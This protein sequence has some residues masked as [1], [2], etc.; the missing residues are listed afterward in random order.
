MDLDQKGGREDL[1]GVDGGKTIIRIHCM[2]ISVFE[3][4]KKER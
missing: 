4:G 3:K 1:G 2:R